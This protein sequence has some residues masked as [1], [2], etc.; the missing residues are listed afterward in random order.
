MGYYKG[1][2]KHHDNKKPTKVIV[3]QDNWVKVYADDGSKVWI[4]Q[5]NEAYVK[6]KDGSFVHIDQDNTAVVIVG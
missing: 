5:D 2:K 3:D 1:K 4:D 6:A